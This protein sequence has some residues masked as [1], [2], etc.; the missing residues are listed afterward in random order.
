MH[1]SSPSMLSI[2][3]ETTIVFRIA[4][5]FGE[6]FNRGPASR[7][8]SRFC[9]ALFL[10]TLGLKQRGFIARNLRGRSKI[11]ERVT[12]PFTIC[13]SFYHCPRRNATER[14]ALSRFL[15][16]FRYAIRRAYACT[17]HALFMY[18]YV[19]LHARIYVYAQTLTMNELC[20]CT[21]F[22]GNSV[23]ENS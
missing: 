6:L 8:R 7:W 9:E 21:V 11:L 5:L 10:C 1:L 18:T 3:R 2:E 13:L 19:L 4:A 22:I 16:P 20:A 15:A 12:L 23:R 17:S 14:L